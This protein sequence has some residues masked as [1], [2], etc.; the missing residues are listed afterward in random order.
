MGENINKRRERLLEGDFHRGWID[1]LGAGDI[2][3]QVI[4]LKMVFRVAGA[5]EV[6]LDRLGVKVG[7]IL[8][9][10]PT[11]QLD[12]VHQAIRRHGVA[13]GKDILQLHLFIKAEQALIKGLRHRL[14][15]GIVG[16]I[17]VER[18]EVRPD[19]HHHIFG[20]KSGGA[21]QGRRDTQRQPPFA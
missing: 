15:Q 4:A 8:E 12:G 14:R 9:F 7:A 19:R 5:V 17:G 13:L 20:G 18:R 1:R 11:V 16:I 3:I 2:F 10:H 21:R 6:S